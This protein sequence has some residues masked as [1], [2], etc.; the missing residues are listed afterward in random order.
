MRRNL[1]L[2]LLLFALAG[3]LGGCTVARS[4][5]LIRPAPAP[6]CAYT[7]QLMTW[8]RTSEGAFS[9]AQGHL[10]QPAALQADYEQAS[11]ALAEAEA[12]TA[13]AGLTA[14]RAAAYAALL[15]TVNS[16]G[17]PAGQ[18]TYTVDQLQIA[19][20]AVSKARALAGCQ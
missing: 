8:L 1:I 17:D 6:E 9:A 7:A 16:F 20:D 19:V 12:S 5:G 13:P 2:G 14:A 4:L 18:R 11:K 15:T 10:D 3:A